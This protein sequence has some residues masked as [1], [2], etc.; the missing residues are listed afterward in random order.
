MLTLLMFVKTRLFIVL[1]LFQE[2]GLEPG[3]III[4]L[5]E[6]EHAV[7]R[8]SGVDLVMKLDINITESLCGFKKTIT[9]LDNRT[10]VIQ[11]IPGW[12]TC[13]DLVDRIS[14]SSETF[15]TQRDDMAR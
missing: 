15:S 5:D 1:I 14:E 7:F 3:D 10:L 13:F 4:V 9:T 2:P 12:Q 6:K 11:T 8:R